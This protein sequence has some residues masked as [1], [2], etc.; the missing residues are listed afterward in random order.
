MKKSNF[1]KINS[2][3]DVKINSI[4]ELARVIESFFQKQN[5]YII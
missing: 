2:D 1:Y 5:K 3:L 4:D